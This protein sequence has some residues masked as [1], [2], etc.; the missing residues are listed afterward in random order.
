MAETAGGEILVFELNAQRFALSADVVVRVER[1]VTITA[2]PSSPAAVAGIINVR[3]ELV[4][5]IALRRHLQLPER[6]LRL[7]DQLVIARGARRA[8]ALLVDAALDVERYTAEEFA[9]ADALAAR[10]DSMRGAVR[11]RGDIVFVHDLDRFLSLDE[12]RALDAALANH[13]SEREAPRV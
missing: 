11:L 7:D 2:M 4:P 6:A 8:Y 5:V 13:T 10:A 9:A 1:A 12:E 3:G